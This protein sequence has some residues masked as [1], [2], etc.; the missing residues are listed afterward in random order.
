MQERLDVH[1]IEAKDGVRFSWNVWPT[2]R[3][4]AA[5]MSVPIGCMY[6]IF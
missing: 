5:R 1:G 2:S 4:E 3:I 6:E